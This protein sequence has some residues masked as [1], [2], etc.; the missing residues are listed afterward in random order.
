MINSSESKHFFP[1]LYIQQPQMKSP[2]AK[3]QS[4]FRFW[5]KREPIKKKKEP[6]V[7][8]RDN[9]EGLE[10]KI[11]EVQEEKTDKSNSENK[12]IKHE[13]GQDD[14]NKEIEIRNILNGIQNIVKENKYP[15]LIKKDSVIQAPE[16][17]HLYNSS[18][19]ESKETDHKNLEDKNGIQTSKMRIPFNQQGFEDKLRYLK[20]IPMTTVRI[21]FEFITTDRKYTGYFLSNMDNTLQIIPN[22]EK[23][24]IRLPLQSLIDIKMI[25]I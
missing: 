2:K 11:V 17:I 15:E 22:E 8:E 23:E 5:N 16:I 3:M 10:E 18:L 12:R 4:N 13:I 24:P 6:D 14:Q 20:A 7:I 9:L 25:G 1:L 21:R 19:Y